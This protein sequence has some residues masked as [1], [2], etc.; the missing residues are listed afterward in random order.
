LKKLLPL[1][2]NRLSPCYSRD[3]LGNHGCYARNDIPRFLHLTALGRFDEAFYVLKETN[4]FSSGCGRFCDHP[5]ETACNRTKYDQPVDIKALERFVSDA[6]YEK[7]LKPKM[8]GEAKDKKIAIVG[9]GPA[10]LSSAYFLARC[11]YRVEVFEKHEVAGGLL[12]EGIP[13]YRYPRDVFEKELAFIKETGVVIHTCANI[14][15][16][17]FKDLAGNYDAV[18]VATGAHKPGELGIEGEQLDGVENGIAFLK[19]VNLGQFEKLG[20]KKGEKIGVIGG[21]YTA[22]DV[23]RCAVRL[24]AEP[25]MVYRRTSAEM[26]AHQGEVEETK[27]EGV[28]FKFLRSPLKIEKAEDALR[29]TVQKMKLGPVDESGRSKPVA[30]YG[31]TETYHFDRIV[32]AIGDKPDLF[33]VGEKFTVDFPRMICRDL[34]EDVQSKIFITGDAAMGAT[35]NTGMV[36]RVVGLAQDT[37]KSVREYLGETVETDKNRKIAFYNTLNTKYFEKSGRLI[38]ETVPFE[39]RNGNFDE[40]VKTVDADLAQLMAGRCFNCGI[41]IQCDWCWHYSDGSLIKLGREWTPEKDAFYYEFLTEKVSDATFKSV[42][43]CPRAA[44]S[45]S[46][47]GSAAESLREEQYITKSEL[48]GGN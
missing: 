46:S 28:K 1:Y 40:I 29:L 33:F 44:L 41:C 31:E 20:I 14:N 15:K 12:T 11:G 32:L 17:S 5:C 37:V 8:T 30:V 7:G 16:E 45:I 39:K 42:E 27:R 6:G 48:E 18:I 26:T 38:E 22:M 36:V 43:A 24:G 23:V 13:A 2:I 35:D 10:G 3:H 19:K 9:S 34:Q 21:G 4:P 47:A 25:T